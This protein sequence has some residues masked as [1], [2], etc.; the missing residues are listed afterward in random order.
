MLGQGELAT[1]LA[2]AIDDLDGHDIRRANGLFALRQVAVDNGIEAEVPPQPA[3]QPDITEASAVAPA[4]FTE[5]NTHDLGIVGQRNTL[6]IGE[7]TQLLRIAVTVIE[8]DGA[9]PAA[10]LIAVQ[11]TEV[12]DDLLTRASIGPCS[13]GSV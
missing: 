6:I 8:D 1:R 11:L 5:A 3:C 13:G 10:F 12:G 9:L 4:D 7:Q 2:Q